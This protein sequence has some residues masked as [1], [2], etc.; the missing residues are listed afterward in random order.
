MII[1]GFD[2]KRCSKKVVCKYIES[3]NKFYENNLN[4]YEQ[5]TIN[6]DSDTYI[7]IIALKLGCLEYIQSNVLSSR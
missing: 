4:I 1:K 2:C 6:H 3:M 5:Y 7:P